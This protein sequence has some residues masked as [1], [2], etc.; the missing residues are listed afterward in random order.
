MH[1]KIA[2]AFQDE[3]ELRDWVALVS[4]ASELIENAGATEDVLFHG[5]TDGRA[6]RILSEG[7]RPTMAFEVSPEDDEE[8]T[9][10]GSFWGRIDVAAWW[11]ASAA[12]NRGGRPVL[13][14]MRT[15]DLEDQ[16]VLGIDI[17]SRDFPQV[18]AA[19]FYNPDVAA[20][21]MTGERPSWQDS[22]CDLGSLTAIH[23]DR[24]HM[25]SAIIFDTIESLQRILENRSFSA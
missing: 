22:L 13:I 16:A 10:H 11:A 7:M 24:I 14:A 9:C 3:T 8:Y 18:D 17:P 2:D 6:K 20:R 19:V 15:E 4:S 21:W 5:T 1:P 12:V 25:D 23:D